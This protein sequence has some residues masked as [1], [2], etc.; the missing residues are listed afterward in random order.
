MLNSTPRSPEPPGE[1][2]PV[3]VTSTGDRNQPFA[4]EVPTTSAGSATG[5]WRSTFTSS[6]IVVEI[7]TELRTVNPNVWTPSAL[8]RIVQTINRGSERKTQAISPPTEQSR[9]GGPSSESRYA[10]GTPST[11]SDVP[12]MPFGSTA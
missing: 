10:T 4:P 2:V 1:S 5:S 7:W 9:N 12:S 8:I 6:V 3:S 11:D